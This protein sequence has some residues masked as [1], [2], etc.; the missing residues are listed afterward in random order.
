MALTRAE[1]F[2][3]LG[4]VVRARHDLSV[5]S[6][7]LLEDTQ[8]QLY[9]QA[10]E[11]PYQRYAEVYKGMKSRVGG[12]PD[13]DHLADPEYAGTTQE[14]EVATFFLD[15]KNFT[16]YCLLLS[17]QTVYQAKGAVIEAAIAIARIYGGHLH[18]IPGD[19]TLVFFGGAQEELLDA[20]G[21]ALQAA[22]DSMALLEE[23]VIPEY[24]DDE[25]YPNIYPKMGLDCG[26][27]L[28]GAYGCR[29]DYEVKATAFNVDIASKMMDGCNAR[30]IAIGD[31]LKQ[32]LDI[33]E[34]EYL[35]RGWKYVRRLTVEG[36]EREVSYQTWKLD[37]RS[38]RDDLMQSD[39]DLSQLGRAGPL[40][41][42]SPSKS[43]LGDAPLA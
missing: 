18:D 33:D 25:R 22:C 34:K 6:S 30:E 2:E 42:V 32:L 43:S 21:R 38:F 12:H 40:P 39:G 28:W 7:S 1:A 27:A 35:E 11:V 13:Y 20:A 24:N 29:P 4:Q 5:D 26:V 3:A 31:D 9:A 8:L 23:V 17:R 19:G 15:L 37:W 16:K 41:K 14:G 10:T 36:E